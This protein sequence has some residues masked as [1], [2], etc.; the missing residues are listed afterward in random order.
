MNAHPKRYVVE[1][2]SERDAYVIDQPDRDPDL[3]PMIV[4]RRETLEAMS[5]KKASEFIGSRLI[6]LTPELKE[7]FKDYLWTDDGHTPPK[8][9]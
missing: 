3:L 1:F 5:L 7:M 8:R 6:L 9:S 4:I 2:D